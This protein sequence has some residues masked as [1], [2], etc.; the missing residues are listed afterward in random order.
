MLPPGIYDPSNAAAITLV[1]NQLQT[2]LDGGGQPLDHTV[3]WLG[4]D[5]SNPNLV[6]TSGEGV[7]TFTI[8]A[9]SQQTNLTTLYRGVLQIR[10]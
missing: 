1:D 9:R 10:R 3:Q 6:L 2:A 7:F 4:Y 8:Q 5:S